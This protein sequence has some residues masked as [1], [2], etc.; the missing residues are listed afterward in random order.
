MTGRLRVDTTG[1]TLSDTPQKDPKSYTNMKL[2]CSSPPK[3]AGAFGATRLEKPWE[4]SE[5]SIQKK[6]TF[7]TSKKFGEFE[8]LYMYTCW[9]NE[10]ANSTPRH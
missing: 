9:I 8:C 2:G 4:F 7:Q 10:T 5:F 1:Q 6:P 3:N